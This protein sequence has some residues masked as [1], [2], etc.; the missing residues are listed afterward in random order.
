MKTPGSAM[1]ARSSITASGLP[2]PIAAAIEGP[3]TAERA[4][5]RTAAR[6]FDRGARIKLADEIFA[7]V[8][9][10]VARRPEMSRSAT[11]PGGGPSPAVGDGAGDFGDGA[12]VVGDGFEKCDDARLALALEHAIDRALAMLKMALAVKEALW[13]PTQMKERG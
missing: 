2:N 6:E 1:A 7:A 3:G 4:V 12:T 13:P 8:A 9:H 5:P 10:Q 11:K